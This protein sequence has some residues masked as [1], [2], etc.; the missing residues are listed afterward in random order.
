MK[1]MTV[2][3]LA[4]SSERVRPASREMAI[5]LADQ[6]EGTV[7][8]LGAASSARGA[9]KWAQELPG[10]SSRTIFLF[11]GSNLVAMAHPDGRVTGLPWDENEV[12]YFDP[13]L[14]GTPDVDASTWKVLIPSAHGEVRLTGGVTC[15]TLGTQTATVDG[16]AAI[17]AVTYRSSPSEFVPVVEDVH[18]RTVLQPSNLPSS[19]ELDSVASSIVEAL[20]QWAETPANLDMLLKHEMDVLTGRAKGALQDRDGASLDVR[21][22]TAEMDQATAILGRLGGLARRI[23]YKSGPK[24]TSKAPT[25]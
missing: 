7:S 3:G 9:S 8:V 2:V 21:R 17:V 11:Q 19:P 14:E 12:T 16:K 15:G 20:V 1:D 10:Q 18:G 22:A 4:Q 5:T 25:P 23:A 6:L 13:S 24:S